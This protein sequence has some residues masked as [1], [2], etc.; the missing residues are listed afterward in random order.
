LDDFANILQGIDLKRDGGVLSGCAGVQELLFQ[1]LHECVTLQRNILSKHALMKGEGGSGMIPRVMQ[2]RQE[3]VD[4]V[5]C[6]ARQKGEGG[7]QT[8][9]R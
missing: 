3:F 8:D 6:E 5:V 1:I 9:Q 7:G 2:F 4:S